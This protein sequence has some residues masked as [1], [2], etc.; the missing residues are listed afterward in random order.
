MRQE[1]FEYLLAVA[2]HW[3]F[4]FG[5]IVLVVFEVAKRIPKWKQSVESVPAKP[6]WGIVG[7]C[8]LI[9]MF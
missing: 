5:G 1:I 9:S 3:F 4:W 8:L 7:A 6:F 2:D